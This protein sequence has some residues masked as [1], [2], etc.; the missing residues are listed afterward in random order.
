M[1]STS[2]IKNGK[3][4]REK[5]KKSS[6]SIKENLLMGCKGLTLSWLKVLRN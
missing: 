6:R 4:M 5:S 1:K 3:K 2:R